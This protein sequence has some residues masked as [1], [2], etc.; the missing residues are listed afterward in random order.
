MTTDVYVR[1]TNG[2]ARPISLQGSFDTWKRGIGITTGITAIE[3]TTKARFEQEPVGFADPPYFVSVP[4]G[5]R[6]RVIIPSALPRRFK[7]HRC[8]LHL[9]IGDTPNLGK[10]VDFEP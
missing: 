2:S 5:E 6:V 9:F 8:Q 7:G 4:S 10:D 3:C 1:L